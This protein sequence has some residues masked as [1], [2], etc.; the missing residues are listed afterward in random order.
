MSKPNVTRVQSATPWTAS[1]HMS[2]MSK[3]NVTRVQSAT[4]WTASVHMSH[5][6]KP[7]VTRVQSATPWTASVHMSHMAELFHWVKNAW[8]QKSPAPLRATWPSLYIHT[9]HTS[10]IMYILY[11]VMQWHLRNTI[12]VL[13]WWP[14]GDVRPP[15]SAPGRPQEYE[16]S[17]G[18]RKFC[19]FLVV[20]WKTWTQE[21]AGSSSWVDIKAS[22]FEWSPGPVGVCQ[23]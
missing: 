18:P 9:S 12:L 7:N 10:I 17:E 3:P 1:V 21:M 16:A 20:E 14:C 8:V 13:M 11:N 23:H 6:S 4:P 2:H 15:I 5:M 19:G 22:L